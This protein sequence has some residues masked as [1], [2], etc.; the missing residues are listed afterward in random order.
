MGTLGTVFTDPSRGGLGTVFEDP[1]YISEFRYK[2]PLRGCGDKTHAI[3]GSTYIYTVIK[4][5]LD[6]KV[7]SFTIFANLCLSAKWI[8]IQ[9]ADGI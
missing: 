3:L 2:A 5:D 8:S 9:L 1:E 6:L 4:T 7:L